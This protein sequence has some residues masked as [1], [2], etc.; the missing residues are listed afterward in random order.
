[1][2]LLV[3]IPLKVIR[4]NRLIYL[5]L[6]PGPPMRGPHAGA[7]RLGSDAFHFRETPLQMAYQPPNV[8]GQELMP[9]GQATTTYICFKA[10]HLPVFLNA[11]LKRKPQYDLSEFIARLTPQTTPRMASSPGANRDMKPF[12]LSIPITSISLLRQ[13]CIFCSTASDTSV[14]RLNNLLPFMIKLPFVHF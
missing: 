10:T 8:C 7:Q 14:L 6:G 13:H 5:N 4:W 2:P 1:M 9:G 11:F 3:R 12:N